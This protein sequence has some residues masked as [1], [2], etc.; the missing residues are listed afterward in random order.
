MLHSLA[1]KFKRFTFQIKLAKIVSLHNTRIK[2]MIARSLPFANEI[3]RKVSQI[4][5]SRK[6]N[7]KR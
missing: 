6:N 3:N 5:L 1:I 4:K 2:K 7:R